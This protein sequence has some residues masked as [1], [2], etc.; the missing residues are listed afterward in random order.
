MEI[1]FKNLPNS[2]IKL[3]IDKIVEDS[4][5]LIKLLIGT[6]ITPFKVISYVLE[7]LIDFFKSLVNPLT[8]PTKIVEL[9]SFS[10]LTDLFIPTNFLKIIGIE[11][12]PKKI[13]EWISL[14]KIPNTN[15]NANANP[16]I[17]L[18]K[19]NKLKYKDAKPNNKFLIPDNYEIADLNEVIKMPFMVKLPTYTA[20]QLRNNPTLPFKLIKPFLGLI[21]SILN[22]IINF[23]WS[24]LGLEALLKPINIELNKESEIIE[25]IISQDESYTQYELYINDISNTQFLY[26][27]TFN[28]GNSISNLT[29]KEMIDYI[30]KNNNIDY[31]FNF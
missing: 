16:N 14:V 28:N 24:L 5:P 22:S 19:K 9:L 4:Q 17:D 29:Y 30:N 2:P 21:E 27:I 18:N 26:D 1:N 3:N 23:I 15:V 11:Y 25:D 7:W 10:W 12:N 13:A 20:R 8:L 6:I 31:E